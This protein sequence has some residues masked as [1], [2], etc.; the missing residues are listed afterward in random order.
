MLVDDLGRIGLF[1]G[2]TRDQL[3][4]LVTDSTEVR[5]EP[6]VDLFREGEVADY[7]WVLIDG[8]M[9]LV[10]HVGLED[11]V[12]RRWDVPGQWAADSAPLT[13]TASTLPPPVE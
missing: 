7:W 9:N 12:V 2:L 8:A 5:F 11:T 1:E 13:S 3:A 10:R 4:E 6:G